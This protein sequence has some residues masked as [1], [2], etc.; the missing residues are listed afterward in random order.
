MEGTPGQVTLVLF[1]GLSF[2]RFWLWIVIVHGGGLVR[3]YYFYNYGGGLH[4]V[5]LKQS[6]VE[7]RPRT[8][9]IRDISTLR[10]T[11]R[12]MAL[13]QSVKF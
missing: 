6:M 5:F 13:D 9:F 10:G 3:K 11:V 12:S 2:V 4:I 7:I 8:Q 1:A